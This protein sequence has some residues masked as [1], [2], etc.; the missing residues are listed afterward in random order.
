MS[1]NRKR[2][3]LVL[4]TLAAVVLIAAVGRYFA[5]LLENE[6]ATR[7]LWSARVE[8]LLP[9]GFLYLAAHTIWGTFWVQLLWSQG[10]HVSWSAGLRAYFVSQLGKYIPGK[11]TVLLLRIVLLRH[12][13]LSPTL[14]AVTAT[15]ETLT[16]MAAGATIAAVLLPWA[17]LGGEWESGKAAALVG[18]AGLPIVLGILNRLVV[19]VAAKHRGPDAKPLPS[20][21][22]WLLGQGLLQALAGWA[23]LGMSLWLTIQALA[24]EPRSWELDDFLRDTSAVAISYVI[25]FVVLFA[26]GGLGA[27]ELLLQQVLEQQV[28]AAQAAIVAVVLRIVWTAFEMVVAGGVFWLGERGRSGDSPPDAPVSTSVSADVSAVPEGR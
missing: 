25:G 7:R 22:V 19:R 5:K 15:Y 13:G 1:W 9:A 23:C 4:K 12:T 27:R 24:E 14:V 18:L 6:D 10:A 28:P 2:I 26:P 21:P 17:G 20:P 16:S 8:Y 3:W 11:A